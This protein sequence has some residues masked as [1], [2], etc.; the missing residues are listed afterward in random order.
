MGFKLRMKTV[1]K[2]D[3]FP[4]ENWSFYEAFSAIDRSMG[5]PCIYLRIMN[6]WFFHVFFLT[7]QIRG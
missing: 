1:V 4:H 3:G 7:R 2:D 6:G 5:R